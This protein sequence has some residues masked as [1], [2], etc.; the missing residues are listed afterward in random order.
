MSGEEGPNRYIRSFSAPDKE[1]DL[2]ALH[3]AIIALGGIQISHDIQYPGWRWRTHVQ[4]LV[5]TEWCEVH[6]V[7]VVLGGR[8]RVELRDGTQFEAGRLD[9][10][11]IPAGHDAWV[12]GDEPCV[13]LAWSGVEGWLAPPDVDRVLATVLFT[14]IVGSTD[15]AARIGDRAWKELLGEHH[16]RIRALLDRFRGAEVD[17]AGDG[18]FATFDSPA[19]AV[20]CA[21]AVVEA[22]RPLGIEIRVGLHTGEL[23]TVDD[24]ASGLAVVIGARIGALATASEILVSQTVKELTAGSGLRFE[25]AGE[26]ELR[27]VPDRWRLH[28]VVASGRA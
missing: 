2:E 28:R 5:G 26:F 7:G 24:K 15:A 22:I 10:M 6:H 3:S 19:R 17:T 16:R 20:R 27:G 8:L 12:V 14:D 13:T 23:E 18:F 11:D 9:L 21:Q 1:V 4:P 25:E